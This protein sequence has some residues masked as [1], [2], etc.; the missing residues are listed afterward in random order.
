MERTE[1]ILK[2][3]KKGIIFSKLIKVKEIIKKK[4]SPE[5]DI[6]IGISRKF[7]SVMANGKD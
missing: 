7:T 4:Y 5:D 3:K 1:P 2:K 6:P